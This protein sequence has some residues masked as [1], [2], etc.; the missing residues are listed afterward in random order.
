MT[1][2]SQQINLNNKWGVKDVTGD[3]SDPIFAHTNTEKDEELDSTMASVREAEK[4]MK[5][6][7]DKAAKEKAQQMAEAAKNMN[8]TANSTANVNNHDYSSLKF[9][10]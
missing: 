8:K 3:G 2:E 7:K 5:V 6:V 10:M 4:E 1:N 9:D